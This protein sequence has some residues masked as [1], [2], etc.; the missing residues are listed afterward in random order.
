MGI[1]ITASRSFDMNALNFSNL[2]YGYTTI[3]TVSTYQLTY[4]NGAK[5]VFKGTGF[6]YDGADIPISGTVTSF[7]EYLGSTKLFS[8]EGLNV[9][10]KSIVKAAFSDT[11]RDDAA[12]VD[13][14]LK[15]NDKVTGSSYA[16]FLFAGDGNDVIN[17]G[18]G[19]DVI[20]SGPGA[21]DLYGG[22]GTDY[23]VFAFK[24]HSTVSTKA[25]DTIFDFTSADRI[26]LSYIDANSKLAGDQSFTFV[27]TKGFSG[28]SGE[29]RY[30]K[31][32]SDTLIY[33]DMNGDKKADFMIHLDDAVTMK[34]GYF[35]L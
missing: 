31:K 10:V 13:V 33:G 3:A 16:D 25:R 24:E 23:F 32:A 12:L 17:G 1:K 7:T 9:S 2:L 11:I 28:R 15:G 20:L 14:V 29:L 5:D 6:K 35:F 27:G 34:A 30:E 18:G 21:D 19:T 26:D 8:L 22:S 4:T